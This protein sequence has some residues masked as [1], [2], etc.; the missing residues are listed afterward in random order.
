[1]RFSAILGVVV[2]SVFVA[3]APATAQEFRPG[4]D[5]NGDGVL[6]QDEFVIWF[7]SVDMKRYDTNKDEVLSIAEFT[8][9]DS[10][11]KQQQVKKFN[12]D[13]DESF[14]APELVE[15]YLA[16]FKNRDKDGSGTISVDEAPPPFLKMKK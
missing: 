2:A 6:D 15:M 5:S 9:K 3:A 11:F 12:K 13:K 14:S 4:V 8:E 1:M 7:A 16:T 10:K